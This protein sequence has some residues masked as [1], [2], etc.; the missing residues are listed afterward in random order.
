MTHRGLL[1]SATLVV[2]LS[3]SGCSYLYTNREITIRTD[4][5]RQI[6]EQRPLIL[7]TRDGSEYWL[8]GYE[9][10]DS[11]LW[12]KG[13]QTAPSEQ[14][15]DGRIPL[16]S[17][18]YL[19]LKQG[20][21]FKSV[22]FAA[23]TGSVVSLA[24]TALQDNQIGLVARDIIRY[25]PTKSCPF[26]YAYDGTQFTFASE[27][28]AGSIYKGSER[29]VID[30]LDGLTSVNGS[31][32]LKLTNERIETDYVNELTLAVVDAPPDVRVLSSDDGVFHTLRSTVAPS[33]CVDQDAVSVLNAVTSADSVFWE[34]GTRERFSR[35]RS[36][37]IDRL[38]AHFCLRKSN[39][40]VKLLVS[41]VNTELAAFAFDQMATLC[42]SGYAQWMYR[43]EHDPVQ[44]RRM[45][46]FLFR[47]GLLHVYVWNGSEWQKAG[48]FLDSGSELVKEHVL[49]LPVPFQAEGVLRVRLECTSDLWRIDRIA[50]DESED[51]NVQCTSVAPQRLSGS[52]GDDAVPLV[53][54]KD[55]RYL[56]TM[57]GDSVLFA[58]DAPP[59]AGGLK[60]TC[61]VRATGYYHH[62]SSFAGRDNRREVDKI[63]DIPGYG[64]RNFLPVWFA[65]RDKERL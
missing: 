27:T 55:D 61:F 35:E 30:R 12:C 32:V 23:L 28:F 56:T 18:E 13:Y 45:R 39:G 51:V 63:L 59:P 3:A 43:L 24:V 14:E 31:Y 64:A 37:Y 60:R 4:L 52:A 40:S 65:R 49:V 54:G 16:D 22:V 21:F 46:Q 20:D 62:W 2:L 26:V 50:L 34:G 33:V 42:G 1:A 25:P 58:F 8:V 19:Y 5:A 47:E 6:A 38:E 15:F 41:G 57:P 7:I 36:G 53:A 48:A 17:V 9:L 11:T 44:E 10:T 29:T